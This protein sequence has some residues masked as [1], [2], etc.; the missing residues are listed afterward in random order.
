MIFDT[1][2]KKAKTLQTLCFPMKNVVRGMQKAT[3]KCIKNQCK[4]DAGKSYAKMM[5]IMLKLSQNGSQNQCKILKMLEKRHAK[6]D[7]E[8]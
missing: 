4:I 6:N 8:I 5:K 3:Q 1:F 2:S 7:A